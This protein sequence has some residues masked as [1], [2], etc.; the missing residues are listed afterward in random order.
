MSE[1]TDGPLSRGAGEMLREARIAAGLSQEDIARELRQDLRVVEALESEDYSAFSAPIFISGYLRA[2]ARAVGLDPEVV[3]N[4]YRRHAGESQP[5]LR[6]SSRAPKIDSGTGF[7]RTV[8]IVIIVLVLLVVAFSWWQSREDAEVVTL[9]EPDGEQLD[10][11][12]QL[13]LPPLEPP[14]AEVP[15]PAPPEV[16]VP[17][18]PEVPAAPSLPLTPPQT[19]APPAAGAQEAAAKVALSFKADSWVEIRDA[20][21]RNVM[22]DVGKSGSTRSVEGT[23]PLTVVLGYAPGV[24]VEYNGAPFDVSP[25]MRQHVARFTLGEAR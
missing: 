6:P 23:P 10:I 20:S 16:P 18:G 15:P 22:L 21:G 5:E 4:G 24:S 8:G 9:P 14:P 1:N 17:G 11:P 3:L 2:Y 12:E 25:Y 13:P 7:S 19:N